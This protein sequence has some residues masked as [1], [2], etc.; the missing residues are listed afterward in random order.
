YGRWVSF[1]FAQ[2]DPKY[3][4]LMVDTAERAGVE[5]AGAVKQS[6]GQTSVKKRQNPYSV[7]S[8][9]LILNYKQTKSPKTLQKVDLG[10]EVYEIIIETIESVIAEHDGATLEQIND[11]LIMKGLELG[12]LDILSERYKDLTPI[13]LD[14]FDYNQDKETFHIREHAKF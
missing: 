11:E 5:Y 1:V 6:N 10:A 14:Q 13:L 4:H 3:W 7:L 2:K 8:S 9:Q 12:F